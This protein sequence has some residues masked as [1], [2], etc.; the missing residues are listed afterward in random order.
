MKRTYDIA[1]LGATPAGYAAAR[2][3]AAKKQDVIV[4]DA[5]RLSTECP[6][7]DWL[8]KGFFQ[9]RGLPK[10][11]ARSS[12]AMDFS[13][14]CYHNVELD[15]QVDYRT[16]GTAGHFVRAA[17]LTRA[18]RAAATKAGAKVRALSSSPAIRLE[19]D[20][21]QLLLGGR[22]TRAR[23]LLIT[24]NRP[25]EVLGELAMPVRNVP[26]SSLVVAGLDVPVSSRKPAVRQV[27]GALHVV[28]LRER[29]EL[30]AFFLANSVL[31]LR[32]I[33]SSV[34]AGTRAAE[35]SGMVSALQQAGVLPADLPLGRAKGAVW[36]PPAGVALE[37]ET[38]VAKRCLLAGTAGGFV[39]SITGQS[40]ASSV[41]SALI[42]ADIAI[43]ALKS[44]EPQGALMKYKTLWRRS[45]ADYLRPPNTSLQ[46]LLPLLFVNQ[47]IVPKFTRALLYGENI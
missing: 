32:V 1:V 37:L 24:H 22:Q 13:R 11:L 41:R 45:L 7:A 17:S 34:A 29:S 26:G 14:V 12:R 18:F 20:A 39:E 2:Y 10:G 6:L 4:V 33:S 27:A 40:L 47:R 5:P 23:L 31:H 35:L 3:L 28:E 8:P 9:L 38:H 16:R 30:G 46:M 21:V 44:P 42:A 19:E 15:K 36:R 43:G 25:D